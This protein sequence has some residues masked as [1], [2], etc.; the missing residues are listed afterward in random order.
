MT[1]IGKTR[2]R[3]YSGHRDRVDI[4]AGRYAQGDVGVLLRLGGEPLCKIS[5]W[6]P[7][8]C[9]ADGEFVLCHDV[10]DDLASDLIDPP[11]CS[12]L[13]KLAGPMFEDTG[14]RVSYGFVKD[15]PVFRIVDFAE[16]NKEWGV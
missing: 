16:N 13:E 1:Y 12:D 7:H 5:V 15:R 3:C 11:G 2:V 9:L 10:S 6:L 4:Y 8:A 14:R